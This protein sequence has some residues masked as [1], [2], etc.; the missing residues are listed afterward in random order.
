MGAVY[1]AR[2]PQTGRDVA[3]KRLRP[4]FQSDGDIVRRFTREGL[5]T[6]QIVH[7]NVANVLETGHDP[8][9]GSLYIVQEFLVGEDLRQR[10]KRDRRLAPDEA[11]RLFAQVADGLGAA[12]NHGVVHRDIKPANIFLARDAAAPDGYVPKVIDFGVSKILGP[13][14]AGMHLT[15]TGAMV[16]TP[17]FMAP[18]QVRGDQ[19]PDERVDIWALGVVTYLALAGENPFMAGNI[20]AVFTR[21]VSFEPPRLDAV[22]PGIPRDLGDVVAHMLGKDPALRFQTMRAVVNALGSCALAPPGNAAAAE[23]ARAAPAPRRTRVTPLVTLI[24]LGVPVVL[25]LAALIAWWP[26]AHSH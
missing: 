11:V 22:V 3:L 19:P 2:D 18:E 12:H 16:G 20:G 25:A 4:M 13:L 6:Q 5:T 26:R 15:R 23:P 21:I 10:L 24:A 8:A 9:D 17:H 7:P 1:R 14:G